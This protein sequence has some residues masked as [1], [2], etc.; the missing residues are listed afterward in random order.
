MTDFSVRC[1]EIVGKWTLTLT[2]QVYTYLDIEAAV[3]NG[4]EE[5]LSDGEI[6]ESLEKRSPLHVL[7]AHKIVF[8]RTTTRLRV[9]RTGM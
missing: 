8:S 1:Q 7:T 4:E 2:K 9:C 3:D 6:G 5:E